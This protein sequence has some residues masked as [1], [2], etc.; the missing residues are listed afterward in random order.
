M[1]VTAKALH[2]IRSNPA[3]P[4]QQ[5]SSHIPVHSTSSS[6]LEIRKILMSPNAPLGALVPIERPKDK[7]N[8]DGDQHTDQVVVGGAPVGYRVLLNHEPGEGEIVRYE[9]W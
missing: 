6:P 8:E 5:S 4:P 9:R 3:P 7:S 2:F 1:G